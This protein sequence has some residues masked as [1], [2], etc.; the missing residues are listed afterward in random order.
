MRKKRPVIPMRIPPLEPSSS[1]RRRFLL[2][3][4]ARLAPLPNSRLHMPNHA[5]ST[6]VLYHSPL[7]LSPHMFM[8]TEPLH[9]LSSR[10]HVLRARGPNIVASVRRT[11]KGH[12]SPRGARDV[13]M[14]FASACLVRIEDFAR[15][16]PTL[17]GAISE[18]RGVDE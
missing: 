6:Y 14:S 8:P 13:H 4:L 18:L 10:P 11:S 9:P 2:M 7:L 16:D 17:W 15:G 1:L 5:H 12:T 3:L